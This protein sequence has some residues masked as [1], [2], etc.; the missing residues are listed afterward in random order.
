MGTVKKHY[1]SDISVMLG[2]SLRLFPPAYLSPLYQLGVCAHRIDAAGR[3]RFC[4][5]SACDLNR[6]Y[7]TRVAVRPAGRY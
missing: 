6:G 7:H 4:R 1:F 3:A 5:T 2:R